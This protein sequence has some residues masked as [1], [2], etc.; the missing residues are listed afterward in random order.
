MPR[1]TVP[2]SLDPSGPAADSIAGLWWLLLGAGTV[3]FLLVVA[4]LVIPML[5]RRRTPESTIDDDHREEVPS[6]LATGWIVG[7]GIVMTGVLLVAVLVVSVTTMRDVSRAAPAGS[8][9][10]DVIGYQY[11]WDVRYPDHGVTT[12]N[13]INIPVGQPVEIRLTSADVIHSFW[14]PEL[15]GKLDAL[16]DGTNVLVLRADR[17][18]VYGGECAEFCGIQHTNMGFRVVAR[19][20]EQFN[21]WL[22]LH[23]QSAAG[24]DQPG[25]QVFR[26]EG[27]AECHVI[28]GV[29]A[30][31][32]AQPGPD[33]THVASR[34]RIA[35]DTIDNTAT[36]LADW[37]RDP[38]AVKPGTTMPTP[39]LT[40]EQIEQLVAYLDG[41]T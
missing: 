3:I 30:D 9:R 5:R 26:A 13:E 20:L 17:P 2:A 16:P 1:S 25:A 27:C 34:E 31:M 36:N 37:L 19:P 4:L 38:G 18:G 11:W 41:L 39:D 32:A 21:G 7:L 6:R 14:A 29:T 40:D 15:H 8:L 24:A 10:I 28:R 22:N 12:A 35:S 23:R 33:L